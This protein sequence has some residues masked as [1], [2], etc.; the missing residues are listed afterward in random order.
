MDLN[1]MIEFFVSELEVSIRQIK[2]SLAKTGALKGLDLKESIF[3]VNEDDP[4]D[5][6]DQ[7]AGKCPCKLFHL[8]IFGNG[9]KSKV[10][11]YNHRYIHHG[12]E[13]C[14]ITISPE[15]KNREYSYSK[16]EFCIEC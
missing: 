8:S 2:I 7:C 15:K 10:T 4:T 5:F 13:K 3:E 1:Q 6:M 9:K 14:S 11:I 16:S 12:Y